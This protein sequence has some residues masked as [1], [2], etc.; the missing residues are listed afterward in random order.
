VT[1]AVPGRESDDERILV[2]TT[3]LVS[4]DIAMCH[5]IYEKAKERGVGIV[6]PPTGG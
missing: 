5:Y 3:G 6:L 2:H 1:G 4:Q